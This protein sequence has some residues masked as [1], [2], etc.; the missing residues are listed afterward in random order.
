MTTQTEKPEEKDTCEEKK[1]WRIVALQV[2][3]EIIL[4]LIFRGKK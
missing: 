2:I 1:G 3:K 4:A